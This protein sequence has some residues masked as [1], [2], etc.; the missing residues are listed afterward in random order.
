MNLDTGKWKAIC[1]NL[2]VDDTSNPDAV[3]EASGIAKIKMKAL[4]F[5]Q[6][7]HGWI[8][9]QLFKLEEKEGV[10]VTE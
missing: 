4:E 2:G 7:G 3:V 9:K 8:D 6:R 1:T 5:I 10:K